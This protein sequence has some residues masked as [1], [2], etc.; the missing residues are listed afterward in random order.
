[1]AQTI[2]KRDARAVLSSL[3]AGVTPRKGLEH[4]AVGRKD[5]V[6]AMLDDFQ[7]S[8][9]EGGGSFRLISGRYGSGKSFLCQLLR[10]YALNQDFVVADA[11]LSPERRLVGTTNG[12]EGIATYRELLKNMATKTRPD[13]GAFEAIL[14]RWIQD[15]QNLVIQE[16][17]LNPNDTNFSSRV[18]ARIYDTLNSMQGLVHGF[19]FARV[20]NEYWWGYKAGDELKV[21]SALR[22]LRGEY[23][24]KTDA[25]RELGVSTIIGDKDW[26]DYL[27]LLARFIHDIGYRGLVIFLDEAVN[28]YKINHSSTR[29]SNY[30]KLLNILNDTLQGGAEYLGV[31]VGLTPKMLEDNQ[32]GLF[33]YEALRTRLQESRYA[34]SGLRNLNGPI[35]RLEMLST[36]EVFV[37]LR[38]LRSIHSIFYVYES[39]VTDEQIEDFMNEAFQR[40]G[41][42]KVLTPRDLVRDFIS[43][44]DLLHQNPEETFASVVGS[45]GFENLQKPIAGDEETDPEPS[46]SPYQSFTI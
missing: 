19:D 26:Y 35:I 45:V 33:S 31:V 37:L 36:E 21:Q 42:E 40:L 30:E 9:A 23:H 29:K 7:N 5:E 27:K 28:L 34:R 39:N 38:N 14:E 11:D 44:L 15:V 13:G 8:V 10:N 3:A 22:W 41:A 6:Q 2:R 43:I 20:L 18:S 25:K 46:E 32:R 1:M 4:I 24:T 16:E 12:R 17:N